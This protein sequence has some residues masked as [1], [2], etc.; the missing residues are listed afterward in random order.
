MT[1]RGKKP[2]K[3]QASS[4]NRCFNYNKFGHF[5]RNCRIPKKSK[6]EESKSKPT[7]QNC[8]HITLADKDNFDLELFRPGIANM[9]K[10]LMQAPKG[11]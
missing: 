11:I 8:T 2:S 4:E 10:E 1:F 3:Q 6:L 5:G 7:L 9:D